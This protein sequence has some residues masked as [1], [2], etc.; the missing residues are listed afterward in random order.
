M[1]KPIQSMLQPTHFSTEPVFVT[2]AS[3]LI[4]SALLSQLIENNIPVK[5]LH[6][7]Q[8]SP[9]LTSEQTEK[10][11]WIKGDILDT[12]LLTAM[13]Q[14]C[15]RVYHC[16]AVVSFHP[17]RREKM[18]QIN[19]EGT[20]NVVNAALESGVE[21]L[22]YVSSVAAIGRGSGD[23]SIHEALQWTEA[24]NTSHY[25]KSKYLA[26]MEVWRGIAEGLPAV[27]VNPAI[28]LGEGNPLQGSSAIY[29]KAW[30]AFS[31]YT[32]GST[33][34]VDAKDVAS[35]MMLLM[36]STIT[37]ERFI[38]SAGEMNY[39]NLLHQMATLFGKNPPSLRAPSYL[40]GLAWRL[41]A[42]RA[43]F[44][45]NEPLLTKETVQKAFTHTRYEGDKIKKWLPA[46]QYT[47]LE[48]TLQRTCNWYQKKPHLFQ[49]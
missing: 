30:D 35:A 10:I 49:A 44:T 26:E 29:K 39:R 20:A 8:Q 6:H 46:F 33:G 45:K 41:E 13:M 25:G 17:S 22:V 9:L 47:P 31:F 21:K 38:L 14:Q 4:G 3:G 34:F 23:E 36:E 27:M 32:E 18:Y 12:G 37:G 5:A 42:L 1:E 2:G 7:L 11:E 16:A 24:Q 48:L 43:I 19:V 15:K 28:V 40:L